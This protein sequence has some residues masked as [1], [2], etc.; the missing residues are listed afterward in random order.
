MLQRSRYRE[1][2]NVNKLINCHFREIN[3]RERVETRERERERDEKLREGMC[4][5]ECER[6]R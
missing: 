5:N 2:E 4:V 6:E 1:D 3:S